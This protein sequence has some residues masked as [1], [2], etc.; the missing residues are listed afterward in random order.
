[1]LLTESWSLGRGFP[2]VCETVCEI[3]QAECE[4]RS[5]SFKGWKNLSKCRVSAMKTHSV[6]HENPQWVEAEETLEDV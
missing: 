6:G 1:M 5:S 3:V 2:C 4:E